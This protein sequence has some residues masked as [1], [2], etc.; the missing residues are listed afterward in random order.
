MVETAGRDFRIVCLAGSAGALDAYREILRGLPNDPGMAFVIVAHRGLENADLLPQLLCRATSMPVVEVT[1]G[2]RLERNKVFLAP[3]HEDIT[4]DGCVFHLQ[5][6]SDPNGWPTAI[7]NFLNSLAEMTGPRAVAVILSGMSGDGSGALAAIK[8]G[9][10]LTFAQS[11]ASYESMP[12]AAVKTGHV[13]AQLS[14]SG[15][16]EKLRALSHGLDEASRRKRH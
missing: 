9:G 5:P 14:S 15:I 2:M 16:A 8:T 3:P 10:G 7:T 1:Q 6:S 13:D 11:D 12:N 4:T